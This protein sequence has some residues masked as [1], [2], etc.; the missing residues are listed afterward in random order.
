VISKKPVFSPTSETLDASPAALSDSPADP[1]PCAGIIEG[2]GCGQISSET[3]SL[4]RGRLRAAAGMLFLGFAAFLIYRIFRGDEFGRDGSGADMSG[5]DWRLAFHIL[6]TVVLATSFVLLCR[7]CA[8]GLTKLR[9]YELLIFGMPVAYFMLMQYDSSRIG[10]HRGML[11]STLPYWMGLAFIYAIFIPNS[12]RRIA[13]I[14]GVV[15]ALPLVM[16]GWLWFTDP[17]YAAAL[18]ANP[19]FEF[20]MVI[21][22]GITYLSATYGTHVIN[23]LRQEVFEAKQL[24]QYR[25]LRMIGAGGMGEVYLAEHQLMKRPVAIKLIRPSKAAD[26]QALARF[27]RE[28]RSTAKLSHWNT[29]EIFDYGRTDD[30]TFYYVMEYLPGLSLSELVERHG[31]LPPARAIHLLMQ[32]C[33]ALAEAHS[34]G[35]IHRDLK[36]GNVF[37]AY[38]GGFHDVAK[39]LDFGLAKPVSTESSSIQLTQ[40]GSITGSPLFMSPEQALGDSEPDARSD[41]YSLGAVAYYLLTGVPPFDGD[42]PIK[43]ILAHAHDPVVPPSRLRSEIAA[44]LEQVVLRCLAKN[45]ADRY[46]DALSLRQALAECVAAG[47]W[48]H[49]DAAR[50]WKSNGDADAHVE[51]L[52]A[53]AV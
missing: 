48:T 7:R 27:E 21:M 14:L 5:G 18:R 51:A 20:E 42:K 28:V 16:S 46:P 41:I 2:S 22:L 37:S 17:A 11:M 23:T 3:A 12:W 8:L 38:R 9:T 36:P 10:A 40:E 44:D 35:L 33:D 43:V 49:Q 1:R 4:L 45:P 31:P 13:L 19:M 50:W 47:G 30:G 6:V 15:C 34:R 25:L 24:G 39:L 32:T 29:I 53:A 52:A 26:P